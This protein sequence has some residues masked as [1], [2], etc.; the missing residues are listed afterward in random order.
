[1]INEYWSEIVIY[2]VMKMEKKYRSFL[3]HIF[4]YLIH[5]LHWIA[6]NY[7]CFFL[8][9]LSACLYFFQIEKIVFI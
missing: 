8:F 1:M 7:L 5:I 6:Q 9:F 4:I 3:K 2:N